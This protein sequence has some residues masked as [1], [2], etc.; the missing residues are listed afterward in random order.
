ACA[1]PGVV[2]A[3]AWALAPPVPAPARALPVPA[4][5][6]GLPEV[7]D[8]PARALTEPV[9]VPVCA[10]SEPVSGTAGES[11]GSRPARASGAASR[12][13]PVSLCVPA[14]RGGPAVAVGFVG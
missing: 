14:V 10:V 4:P 12:S 2:A 7:V 6:C 13:E 1:L 3:P 5:A 8:V 11:S 9:R